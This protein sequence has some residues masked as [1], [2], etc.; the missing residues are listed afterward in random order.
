ML[1]RPDVVAATA[2]FVPV[3]SDEGLL[4]G[5]KIDPQD[6]NLNRRYQV[7]TFPTV[8][9]A[10]PWGNETIR[11][12]GRVPKDAF[13]QVVKA[14]P[15]DFA[16]IEKASR[17]LRENP[18]SALALVASAAFY[19][20]RG[21]LP[22]SERLFERALGMSELTADV[23]SRRQ[24]VIARGMNLMRMD[25]A[26]EAARLFE[27]TLAEAPDGP[28]GDALLFGWLAALLQRG[29]A[30]EAR[31]VFADLEKRYPASPYTAKAKQNLA[32]AGQPKK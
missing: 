7:A 24:V 27:R 11:L 6:R 29:S 12:V 32:A 19:Q 16:P 18:E 9:F 14:I 3:L 1:S 28:A 17:L 10:D 15:E 26:V 5:A 31:S 20:D 2:R 22:V 4:P 21:L 13:L 23:A 8:L 25:K 30:K